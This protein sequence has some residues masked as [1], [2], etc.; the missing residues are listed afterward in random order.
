MTLY[1]DIAGI[2]MDDATPDTDG[3]T[4]AATVTGWDTPD[5]TEN[6]QQ[7]PNDDGELMGPQFYQ[8]RQ[9]NI[10]MWG[11]AAS[12]DNIRAARM[13]ILEKFE[14]GVDINVSSVEETPWTA[15][16]V[17]SGKLY[18]KEPLPNQIRISALVRCKD[19]RKYGPTTP[20]E[21]HQASPPPG[22]IFPTAL[23]LRLGN[24]ASGITLTNAGSTRA[25]VSFTF[26]GPLPGVFWIQN[27]RQNRRIAYNFDLSADD[28]LTVD[29]RT[30]TVL[31]NGSIS[32]RVLQTPDSQLFMLDPGETS[33]Q[34]GAAS[35]TAGYVSGSFAIASMG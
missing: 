3:V 26:H 23:P 20:F 2:R 25:P 8:G 16:G 11:I 35:I 30:G 9:M 33:L 12:H 24:P 5:T 17:R 6:W 27:T 13:H 19:P 22:I 10:E 32:Y 28:T 1:W 4:W 7:K 29:S 21:I 31:L 14:L 18:I 34:F 15:R